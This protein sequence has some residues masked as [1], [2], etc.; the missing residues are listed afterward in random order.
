MKIYKVKVNNKVYEVELEEVIETDKEIIVESNRP[1]NDLNSG[2]QVLAPLQGTVNDIKVKVNDKVKKGDT[3]L[4]LEA[5]KM[6][7]EIASSFEGTVI[8]ILVSKDT[9]VRANDVLLVID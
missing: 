8:S 2:N 6:Q 1:K 9:N 5:M 7:T 4:I 3:L